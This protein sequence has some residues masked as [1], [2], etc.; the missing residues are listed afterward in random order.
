MNLLLVIEVC[1]SDTWWYEVNLNP[2]LGVQ[3]LTL[4]IQT[5]K[6]QK[7]KVELHLWT[8]AKPNDMNWI[9]CDLTHKLEFP[10]FKPR[11]VTHV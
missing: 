11:D 4:N 10:N 7:P 6:P 1:D 8:L 5:L 3:I 2:N 9:F